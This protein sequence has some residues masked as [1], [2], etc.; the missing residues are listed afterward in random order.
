MQRAGEVLDAGVLVLDLRRGHRLGAQQER[1]QRREAF[2]AGLVES[3]DHPHRCVALGEQVVGQYGVEGIDV[4]RDRH[5][6][7][8]Q[9]AV[10]GGATAV[11]LLPAD[12]ALFV[13]RNTDAKNT[14]RCGGRGGVVGR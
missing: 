3:G 13:G 4:R 14:T 8:A 6:D 1:G 10:L 12:L 5:D 9:L 11:R 7:H 2:P